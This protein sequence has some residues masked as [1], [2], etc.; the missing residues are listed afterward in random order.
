MTSAHV[1]FTEKERMALA[2]D[3]KCEIKLEKLEF[4]AKFANFGVGKLLEQASDEPVETMENIRK[5]LASTME[6]Y[7]YELD[8]ISEEDL[9]IDDL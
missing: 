4:L 1:E 5:F 2:F 8:S 9:E 6:G 3:P 7:N